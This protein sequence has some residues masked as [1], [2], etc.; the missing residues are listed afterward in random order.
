MKEHKRNIW[1]VLCVTAVFLYAAIFGLGSDFKGAVDMRFGIDIRGGVEAVFEPEGVTETPSA[2][3]LDAARTVIE[4]RLDA[5]NILD[6]EVTADKEH[7]NI[8]VRFPWKSD[9]K[10]FN[11]EAAIAELGETAKL[12]FRDSQGNV[13]VEGKNV[14]D[15]SVVKNKQTGEYE[16]SLEFDKQGAEDFADATEKLVGQS[17]G[18]YMD[19]EQISNP[20][21]REAI[22]GGQA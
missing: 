4:N 20:V 7:G 5:Q 14:A 11:P 19:E 6:R 18:I 2:E 16:V 17:M 3:D 9:E 8:I 12:T 13:L 10:K 1:I 15:S 22:K 21:V